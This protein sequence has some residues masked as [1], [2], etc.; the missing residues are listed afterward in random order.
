MSHHEKKAPLTHEAVQRWLDA[1]A[2]AWETYDE[3]DVRALFSEDAEYRWHPYDDPEEGIEAIVT[4]WL[5]P[6]GN[7]SSRDEPGTYK[8]ELTPYAVDGNK[9]VAIGTCTYWTDTSRSKVARVYYN[10]WLLEFDDAG[11]CRNFVEY[12]MQP[13]KS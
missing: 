4:G 10:N 3:A 7:A 1:Y 6:G 11:K 12:Y 2:H 5:N 8:A 9:A 13:R